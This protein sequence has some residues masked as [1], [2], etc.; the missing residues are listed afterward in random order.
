MEEDTCRR[1][2]IPKASI[3]LPNNWQFTYDPKVFR[4]ERFLETPTHK[5]EPDPRDYI[6]G[7]GRRICP[8]RYVADNALFVTI[9]QTFA[10]FN[11]TKFLDKNGLFVEPEIKFELGAISHPVPYRCSIKP[12][13]L[14][15][16]QLIKASEH[17]YPWEESDAKEL[18]NIK[19]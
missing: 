2:R 17:L 13:S 8:G 6:F 18:E 3:L 19:W 16:E 5:S 1:H 14:A 4:L 9:A 10:V 12:R 11:I 7:Y 15:H